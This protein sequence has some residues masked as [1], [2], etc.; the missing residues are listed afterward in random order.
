MSG[1]IRCTSSLHLPGFGSTGIQSDGVATSLAA[2]VSPGV[3]CACRF[4][5]TAMELLLLPT[6]ETSVVIIIIDTAWL[7]VI[8]AA[9]GRA[10]LV[11]AAAA[12][13][14][15]ATPS[16]PLLQPLGSVVTIMGASSHHRCSCPGRG[17]TPPGQR[18]LRTRTSRWAAACAPSAV[19]GTQTLQRQFRGRQWQREGGALSKSTHAQAV[20]W[21][22]L[23]G[24]CTHA[25]KA[26][27]Q[28]H[29]P[30]PSNAPLLFV[31]CLCPNHPFACSL[32]EACVVCFGGCLARSLP[33]EEKRVTA[34]TRQQ[35]QQRQPT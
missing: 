16:L 26:G 31:P 30:A 22:W 25:R 32:A 19:G 24:W 5:T 10:A 6:V 20:C 21:W 2:R 23:V 29:A 8:T 4:I 9:A 34:S 7:L 13:R 11:A 1:P 33:R 17:L 12:E 27:R 18:R 28:H 3:M 15:A 35:Q 14:A